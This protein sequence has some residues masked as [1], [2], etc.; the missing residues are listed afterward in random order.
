MIYAQTAQKLI[1]ANGNAGTSFGNGLT[2]TYWSASQLLKEHEER[3]KRES[4]SAAMPPLPEQE[5]LGYEYTTEDPHYAPQYNG[6]YDPNVH[7]TMADTYQSSG[8]PHNYY[9]MYNGYSADPQ[10]RYSTADSSTGGGGGGGTY[11]GVYP[12]YHPMPEN[13]VGYLYFILKFSSS[14]SLFTMQEPL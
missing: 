4:L 12:G 6:Y 9:N 8:N 5:N 13:Q 1:T 2:P 10:Q 3:K 11:P 7:G 14:A